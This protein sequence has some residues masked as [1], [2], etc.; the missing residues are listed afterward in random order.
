M[1][2]PNHTYR[3]MDKEGK[4]LPNLIHCNRLHAFKTR[5]EETHETN[6]D[7]Q[8]EPEDPDDQG[9]LPDNFPPDPPEEDQS[10]S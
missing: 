5:Q 3:L 4:I 10:D 6:G 9:I 1:L 8:D 2:G 7:K